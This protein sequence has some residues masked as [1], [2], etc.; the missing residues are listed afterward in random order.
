V[1]SI[2]LYNDVRTRPNVPRAIDSIT[3]GE[4]AQLAGISEEVGLFAARLAC[5]IYSTEEM[6]NANCWGGGVQDKQAL[7]PIRL[8]WIVKKAFL[9]V[10]HRFKSMKPKARKQEIYGG[11]NAKLRRPRK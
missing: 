3:D 5:A 8:D 1:P 10:A 11:I 2:L 9:H 7:D 6:Q 4:L